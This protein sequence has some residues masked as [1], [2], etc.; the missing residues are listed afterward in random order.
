MKTFKIKTSNEKLYYIDKLLDEYGVHIGPTFQNPYTGNMIQSTT[1]NLLRI[2][3]RM[4]EEG[5]IPSYDFQRGEIQGDTQGEIQEETNTVKTLIRKRGRPEKTYELNGEKGTLKELGRHF[6]R[7]PATIR[8][9]S[10]GNAYMINNETGLVLRVNPETIEVIRDTF[11]V[12]EKDA[13][14]IISGKKRVNGWKRIKSLKDAVINLT[15]LTVKVRWLDQSEKPNGRIR[16]DVF[17]ITQSNDNDLASF[18][19]DSLDYY[20]SKALIDKYG[21]EIVRTYFREI[22][23]KPLQTYSGDQ[24]LKIED[25]DIRNDNNYHLFNRELEPFECKNFVEEYKKK[26]KVKNVIDPKTCIKQYLLLN[27]Y[28]FFN[29]SYL[30]KYDKITLKILEKLCKEKKIKLVVFDYNKNVLVSHTPTMAKSKDIICFLYYKEHIYNIK[31]VSIFKKM[32]DNN[33]KFNNTTNIIYLDEKKIVEKLISIFREDKVYPYVFYKHNDLCHI[34]YDDKHY[35]TNEYYE[36]CFN[37]LKQYDLLHRFNIT[38]DITKCV[39]IVFKLYIDKNEN[40]RYSYAPLLNDL[41]KS[42]FYYTNRDLFKSENI[43]TID[44]NK[45]YSYVL[46]KL[47]FLPYYHTSEHKIIK[48]N[49]DKLI[50]H[51]YYYVEV[52]EPTLLIP[53]NFIYSGLYLKTC[54]NMSKKTITFDVKLTIECDRTENLYSELINDLY[55]KFNDKPIKSGINITIGKMAMSGLCLD[56]ALKFKKICCYDEALR[57]SGDKFHYNELAEDLYEIFDIEDADYVKV[58]NNLLVNFMIKDFARLELFKFINENNIKKDDI[59]QIKVDSVSFIKRKQ[60]Y[61]DTYLDKNDYTKWKEEKFN[62]LT[63]NITIINDKL[64]FQTTWDKTEHKPVFNSNG[65]YYDG[66]AGCGKS[67]FIKNEIIPK[68]PADDYII[69][70]PQHTNN[71]EYIMED[72]N[73]K[74][75]QTYSYDYTR[76]IDVNNIIVDEVGLLSKTMIQRLYEERLRGKNIFL[77]GDWRQLSP[78]MCKNIMYNETLIRLIA[79]ENYYIFSSNYRNNYT[80]THYKRMLNPKLSFNEKVMFITNHNLKP[81][82][83]NADMIVCYTNNTVDEYNKIYMKDRGYE[84]IKSIGC[85]VICIT[86]KLKEMNIYNKSTF[87]VEDVKDDVIILSGNTTTFYTILLKDYEK[88]FKPAYARTLYSL[89]GSNLSGYKICDDMEYEPDMFGGMKLVSDMYFFLKPDVLYTLLSR[90]KDT[91]YIGEYKMNL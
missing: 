76:K 3:R 52:E 69:L 26:S 1:N 7:L 34:Y 62:P 71:Q 46:S 17:T 74:V 79:D 37:I 91:S 13:K 58:G 49:S 85:Y 44:K 11:E 42:E 27:Y 77:F 47:P 67:Y 55:T 21:E 78:I 65:G 28:K 29:Q 38:N 84:N 72:F 2:G 8:M 81:Q 43:I 35:T 86:N 83:K 15:S 57:Y 23:T 24:E 50:D 48:Y 56:T 45:C 87:T 22:K 82:N 18:N 4:V 60:K 30:K 88:N 90:F 54:I 61:L 19:I 70:T 31:N 89:Q 75:S 5:N 9:Y 40:I 63:G 73:A 39:E 51:Y 33:F 10:L 12:G 66:Y 59:V 14:K 32:G 64:E 6:G 20:V 68:L 80:E 25:G 53:Q 16:N 36:C 41:V